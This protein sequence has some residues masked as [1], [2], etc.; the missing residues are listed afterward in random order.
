MLVLNLPSHGHSIPTLLLGGSQR[1]CAALR[2]PPLAMPCRAPQE[3]LKRALCRGGP[4]GAYIQGVLNIFAPRPAKATQKILGNIF[5]LN[6][7]LTSIWTSTHD[8]FP[9]P[10]IFFMTRELQNFRENISASNADP[11]C[12][13]NIFG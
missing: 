11:T 2:G 10:S 8:P 3:P 6:L 13:L 12:I 1:R 4:P 7:S 5:Q 9:A